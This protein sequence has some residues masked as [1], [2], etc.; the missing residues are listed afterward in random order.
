[1]KEYMELRD[2]M[3]ASKSGS[4]IEIDVNPYGSV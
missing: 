4:F 2:R 1:M 3:T